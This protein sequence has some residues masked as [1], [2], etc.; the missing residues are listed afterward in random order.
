MKSHDAVRNRLKAFG[1]AYPEAHSKSPW[2]GHDDVAVRNKTFAY[3]SAAGEPLSISCKLPLTGQMALTL[4]FTN[5]T[6]YGLGKSG[7]VTATFGPKDTPP[8]DLLEDW[9]DESYR[10]QAPKKLV[11]SLPADPRR[12]E[13]R[14]AGSGARKKARRG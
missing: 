7:W 14:P 4:P 5:P 12:R 8:I 13:T 10:A 9:I 3:L 2:P 1:L 11:S 6:G